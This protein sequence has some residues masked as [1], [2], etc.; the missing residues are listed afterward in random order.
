MIDRLN[1]FSWVCVCTVRISSFVN[2]Q[3]MSF[4]YHSLGVNE[5]MGFL[6]SKR[7]E[8]TVEF[9]DTRTL[10]LLFSP[11][12]HVALMRQVWL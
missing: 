4:V 11:C 5:E 8:G 3:L 7:N 1:I 10:P 2:C 12:I 6:G 9:K